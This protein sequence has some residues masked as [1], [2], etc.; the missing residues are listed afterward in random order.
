[1]QS[2]GEKI[3]WSEQSGPQNIDPIVW[4]RA[5]SSAEIFW[6]GKQPTGAALNV[7]EALPRLHASTGW[8]SAASMPSIPL[9]PQ[10][11]A[12][13]LDACDMYA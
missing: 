5:A 3:L 6:N 10:W 9:Q 2:A 12:F 1:E 4:Q 7:T 13:R 8:Y 11:C